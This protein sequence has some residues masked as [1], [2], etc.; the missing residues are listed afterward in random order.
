MNYIYWFCKRKNKKI[1]WLIIWFK[2]WLESVIKTSLKRLH[3][4]TK[5]LFYQDWQ[6][7]DIPWTLRSSYSIPPI[8]SRKEDTPHPPEL[9][10]IE[11]QW[12]R[13]VY[14]PNLKKITRINE[15]IQTRL[16]V[17]EP[18]MRAGLKYWSKL[19]V[20]P[21]LSYRNPQKMS[22]VLFVNS[23]LSGHTNKF[24]KDLRL[25]Y[26]SHVNVFSSIYC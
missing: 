3:S 12:S 14:R 24:L 17:L 15:K 5:R 4:Y 16:P 2:S 6:K 11:L 7:C 19:N 13:I 22:G 9:P 23:S 1:K 18:Q 8:R 21:R 26:S 25:R 10:C 20:N